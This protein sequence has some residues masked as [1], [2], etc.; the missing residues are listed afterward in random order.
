[1]AKKRR[2]VEREVTNSWQQ[3]VCAGG[4]VYI[5]GHVA[6]ARMPEPSKWCV[7]QIDAAGQEIPTNPKAQWY[8][9]ERQ[10]FSYGGRDTRMTALARAKMFAKA[11]LGKE[12]VDWCRNRMGDYVPRD[13]NERFPLC[14]KG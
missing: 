6:R 2:P 10:C 5:A 9:Y 13:V 8:D 7:I 12:A 3:I 11:L 4:G 1:M 14:R